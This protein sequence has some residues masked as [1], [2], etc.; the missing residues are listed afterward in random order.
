MEIH[1]QATIK[2]R[3]NHIQ[4]CESTKSIM[5]SWPNYKMPLGYKLVPNIHS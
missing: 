3:L 4:T 5:D 2:Y 1:W